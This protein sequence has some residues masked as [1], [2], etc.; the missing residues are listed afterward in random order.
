MSRTLQSAFAT[1]IEAGIAIQRASAPR[2]SRSNRRF[3]ILAARIA[4]FQSL[5]V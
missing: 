1:D 2:C 4:V 3:V 5:R